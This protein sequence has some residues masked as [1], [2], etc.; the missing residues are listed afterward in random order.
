MSGPH[1]LQRTMEVKVRSMQGPRQPREDQ[2]DMARVFL[3]SDVLL[4]LHLK[5]EQPCYLWKAGEESARRQ[6]AIVWPSPNKIHKDIMQMW[7]TFR[8]TC[9]FKLEDRI[10]ISP[11]EALAEVDSV[12]LKE[13]KER[14]DIDDLEEGVLSHWEY[15]LKDKLGM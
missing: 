12:I 4:D 3:S 7:N 14:S 6:Q 11:S 2:K 9:G 13:V 15:V 8:D 10:V 5:S 1:N